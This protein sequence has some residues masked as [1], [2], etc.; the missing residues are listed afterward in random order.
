MDCWHFIA[1]LIQVTGD[2]SRKAHV[3]TFHSLKLLE[4]EEG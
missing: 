2:Y 1:S 3:K 4:D